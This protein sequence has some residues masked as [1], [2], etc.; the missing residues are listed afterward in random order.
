MSRQKTKSKQ[1]DATQAA[2]VNP[3]TSEATPR[4]DARRAPLAVDMRVNVAGIPLK[5]PVL[6]ASGTFG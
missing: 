1:A 5:N 2:A 3:A 6:A 4:T